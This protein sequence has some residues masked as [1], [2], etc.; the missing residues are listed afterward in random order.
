MT[1]IANEMRNYLSESIQEKFCADISNII[2]IARMHAGIRL[3]ALERWDR[4][5]QDRFFQWF[6]TRDSSD[7]FR[8]KMGLAAMRRILDGLQCH[9][10]LP[11]T[12]EVAKTLGCQISENNSG[13]V[14]AVCQ[15]PGVHKIMLSHEFFDLRPLSYTFD[16]QVSTLIHEVAH[17]QESFG[18]TNIG[19]TYSFSKARMLAQFSSADAL[20]NSDNIAAYILVEE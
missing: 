2:G 11:L 18:T 1:E 20:R 4:Q 13:V 5:E 12:S 17:F 9:D 14:A 10:F 3:G 15:V 19:E 7:N 8:I 6:G 16:S